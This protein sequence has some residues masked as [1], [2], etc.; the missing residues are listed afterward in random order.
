[1]FSL[2]DLIAEV[3]KLLRPRAHSSGLALAVEIA[4]DTPEFLQADSGRLR[5]VLLNLVG[6]G[7]KFTDR[8]Q[9]TI[10]VRVLHQ[11]DRRA[12]LRFEVEDTGIGMTPEDAGRV[13][14]PFTQVDSS[15]SR[16][17][18]GTGLG[19]AISRRIME[20]MGGRMGVESAPGQGSC[21]WFEL[22]AA[23][24]MTA[25]LVQTGSMEPCAPNRPTAPASLDCTTCILVVEDHD[26]NRRLVMFMLESLG[27]RA[28]FVGNGLEAIQAWERYPYDVIL[29]D[30]QM[31]EMDGFEATREIRRREAAHGSRPRV[32]IIALTANAL[33]GDRERCLA[34]GMDG[35]I[36]KPFSS[37]DLQRALSTGSPKAMGTPILEAAATS[38]AELDRDRLARLSAELGPENV[39]ALLGE[40]IR[41]LPGLA[42]QF[43][44]LGRDGD[45]KT[46]ARQAHSL[47]GIALSFGLSALFE[48]CQTLEEAAVAPDASRVTDTLA[49]LSKLI[50]KSERVL[51]DWLDAERNPT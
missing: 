21:F 26:T 28:E 9:V 2:R 31:P 44:K 13:F 37:Q 7:I 42:D 32:R 36:S 25:G 38:P 17:R 20:R 40:F 49:D 29:M 24:G 18:G 46:L 5:Q 10:H 12:Q 51:S 1:V 45:Y 50:S 19:L 6:N 34:A 22:E 15:A 3:V 43:Q 30:C 14:E 48:H 16:S 23:L 35:Y 41:D 33:I 11:S 27:Y 47:Q 4:S 39:N 8:G